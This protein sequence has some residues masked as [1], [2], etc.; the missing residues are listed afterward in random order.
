MT[1]CFKEDP[2]NILNMFMCL[3]AMWSTLR[4]HKGAL[5]SLKQLLSAQC[6]LSFSP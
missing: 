4:M 2:P 1:K 5:C 3:N 6:K